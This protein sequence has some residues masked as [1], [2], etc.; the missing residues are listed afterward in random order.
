MPQTS[1]RLQRNSDELI[2]DEVKEIIS[3]RPHWMIR[4]GNMVFLFV[5]LLLLFLTRFISYPDIINGSARLVSLNAPKMI[6]TRVQ[7]KILKLFIRDGEK[8]KREKHLGYM[9]SIASYDEV[10]Q[11]QQ[12]VDKTIEVTRKNNYNVLNQNP[13]PVL[14]NLGELQAGYQ[15]FQN[16]LVETKQILATGYYQTKKAALQKDLQFLSQLKITTYQQKE[17]LE[18][19][20]QLQKKELEAYETLEKEKVIAPLELNQYKSKVIS[21][22]QSLTQANTQI[23]N[24]NIAIHNKHK[25]LM[26][27]EKQVLDQQQK[28]HSSLLQLKSE[29]EKWIQQYVLVSPEEGTLMFFGSLQ[30]N[31]SVTAGKELF[32]VQPGHTSYYAEM[33]VSQKGFG[34]IKTGQQVILKAEGYPN[35]EFGFLKGTVNYI[36]NMPNQRD[37]F[38]V[39]V[40]LP[41]GLKTNY[42]KEV[43]FSNNLS[44]QAEIITDNRKL[45]DR[46]LGQLKKIWER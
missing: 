12:W 28:F 35:K 9:E 43:S 19:D 14:F 39:K 17:L 25:E 36:S 6:S 7:G 8:V 10:M 34:K 20:Q 16:Q 30:E 11:L 46:L 29:I 37:S 26:E 15:T 5:L 38:L 33:I 44:A 32:Y 3:Y 45:F 1:D 40:N 2:S 21:K 42:N 24:S 13:L 18:Q 27:L 31:Q 22:D 23:T 4:K 41:G